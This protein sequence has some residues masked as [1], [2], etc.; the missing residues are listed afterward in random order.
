MA[1]PEPDACL[2]GAER[3]LDMLQGVVILHILHNPVLYF[4]LSHFLPLIH[5][6]SEQQLS[7]PEGHAL[8]KQWRNHQSQVNALQNI[9]H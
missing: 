1:I 2:Q 9:L 6:F 3:S 7:Y 4:T 5:D 8:S